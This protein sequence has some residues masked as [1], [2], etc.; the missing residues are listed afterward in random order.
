MNS[1]IKTN[2]SIEHGSNSNGEYYKFSDGTLICTKLVTFSSVAITKA[3][4]SWYESTA[5]QN[6]GNWAHAFIAL[7][8][9]IIQCVNDSGSKTAD[10]E[11]LGQRST[12]AIGVAF[13]MRPTSDTHKCAF[14]VIGIGRWK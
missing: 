2:L 5:L 9:V 7:P 14:S 11:M 10:V 4:G 8:S 1:I 12:T 3:F 6:F 13:L